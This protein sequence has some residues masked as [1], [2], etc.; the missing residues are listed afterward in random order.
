VGA[1]NK[2]R[3][4]GRLVDASPGPGDN[5]DMVGLFIRDRLMGN[6]VAQSDKR[7]RQ[8]LGNLSQPVHSHGWSRT[9]FPGQ[10]CHPFSQ[11]VRVCVCHGNEYGQ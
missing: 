2:K 1:D 6:L 4:A 5:I 9:D 7:L 11:F 3:L 8:I 10:M